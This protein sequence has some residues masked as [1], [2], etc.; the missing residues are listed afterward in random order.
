MVSSHFVRKFLFKKKLPG[1][2]SGF[3][4]DIEGAVWGSGFLPTFF[5]SF[6]SSLKSKIEQAAPTKSELFAPKQLGKALNGENCRSR[7]KSQ[8]A[9]MMR[10]SLNLR[11]SSILVL[12]LDKRH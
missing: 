4:G 8:S 7:S 12:D 10:F 5:D 2:Y 6:I 9:D 11:R 1:V 3:D